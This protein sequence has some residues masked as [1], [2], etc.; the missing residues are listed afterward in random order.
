MYTLGINYLSESSVCLFKNNKLIYAVSEERLNRKKNWYGIP[1]LS[2]KKTLKDNNLKLKDI[3]Y[4]ATHGLS[5]LKKDTPDTISYNQKIKDIQ[6][7]KLNKKLKKYLISKLLKRRDHEKKVIEIRT[8]NILI[9]L[10]KIFKSIEVFDHHES[11]A[12]SAFYFSN[13][14]NAYT[15]TIDGWGDNASSKLFKT[16]N[17]KLI[18]IKRTETINSLGYFY[19]SFTKLL[20]FTP[21][22][23]EGKVLGLAAFASPK[24]AIKDINL[25][26][27]YNKKSKNFEGLTH[28]GFYLPTFNN[29]LLNK[30]K[31][32][33]TREEIASAIQKKLEDV[34]IEYIN[35]INKKKFNLALAGGIFANV[36]LN[37]KILEHK[38]IKNIFIFPNM[39][40]GGL[41]VGAAA[42]CLRKNQ[43]FKKF[44]TKDMYL[45]PK[46]NE[47]N[48]REFIK[49]YK[50][51]EIK[52]KN[53]YRFIAQNLNRKKIFSLFQGRME[54]GPRALCN[55]SIICS[56]EDAS[57]N[58]SLNKKLQ[59]TEFM[60][61]APIV[62]KSDF[63]RYFKKLERK[64]VNSKF[65]TLTFNCKKEL[66][67]IAP[68]IVHVDMTA[69][70]Q[71]IEKKSNPKIYKI[72]NEYK[73]ITGCGVLINTS[74]NMHEEPIVNS[75]DDAFR[76]FVSSKIDYLI[77][78]KRIFK[79]N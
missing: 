31:N 14:T 70:P 46:Y 59:R 30:F 65:M 53:F 40:D 19:G 36:K 47:D 16:V 43:N 55:R 66:H 68:A 10:K 58:K 34:V 32:K 71:I 57:I 28:K 63:S 24:K 26:F 45:G 1:N 25:V 17:G 6:K 52:T 76:A 49:K 4:V 42:L 33:Y 50:V 79:N 12:A 54:F 62:L 51:A 15:L 61:F 72:L 11:H 78:G 60:P 69:R 75:I 37:Q 38:K 35:D 7:G 39:G 64:H 29:S 2:I 20:G 41:C 44:V 9:K 3:K 23:H 27:G 56:A 74:F 5:A 77:V 21:H 8:K 67:K 22:K 73:K 48:L 13:F 18:E